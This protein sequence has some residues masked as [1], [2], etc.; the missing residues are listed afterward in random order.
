M[1]GANWTM[2][3]RLGAA[4]L[5]LRVWRLVALR[6]WRDLRAARVERHR[7][8]D[9]LADAGV[10]A[11]RRSALW[12]DG[13]EDEF[14]LVAGKVENLR[15]ARRAFDGVVV[16]AGAVFSFW[17]QLGRP[18]RG[19]GFV[20]GREI[21][22]GCVVP[23]I[24]GGLCQ[25]SNALAACALECGM[26]LVER[27]AHTARIE[28]DAVAPDAVAPPR[29]G[30]IERGRGGQTLTTRLDKSAGRRG[31]QETAMR[32][33]DTRCRGTRASRMTRPRRGGGSCDCA[34]DDGAFSRHPARSEAQS[35]D[36]L[37]EESFTP[38]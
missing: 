2:P 21:R 24:A 28:R 9:A 33:R 25:L 6:A 3:T 8:G 12:R 27:H 17:R 22:A 11:E 30:G 15:V 7:A 1:H 34:Q 18:T 38:P 16:P 26:T 36:P 29:R 23:V 13:R 5:R 31:P 32:R 20:E 4:W 19:R 35:Q 14:R 37:R 10:V